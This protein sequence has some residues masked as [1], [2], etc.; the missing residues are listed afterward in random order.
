MGRALIAFGVAGKA[1]ESFIKD[2]VLA[3]VAGT[4]LVAVGTALKNRASQIVKSHTSGSSLSAPAPSNGSSGLVFSAPRTGASLQGVSPSV[5]GYP[6]FSGRFVASGRD[7]VAVV[8][9]EITAQQETGIRN[10]LNITG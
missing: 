2:P 1:I 10:P 3:V 4:A 7:L 9:T 5:S 6:V 8:G